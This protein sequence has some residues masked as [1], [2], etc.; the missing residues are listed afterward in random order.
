MCRGW[1]SV[2]VGGLLKRGYRLTLRGDTHTQS[3]L[4]NLLLTRQRLPTSS[5]TLTQGKRFYFYSISPW[6]RLKNSL[7]TSGTL[8]SYGTALLYWRHYTNQLNTHDFILVPAAKDPGCVDLITWHWWCF[9]IR[10]TTQVSHVLTLQS[11]CWQY[12]IGRCVGRCNK[13]TSNIRPGWRFPYSY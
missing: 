12:L 6:A 1:Y 13:E 4:I 8:Q 11:D 5:L 9:I 3:D 7:Q 10:D 2:D